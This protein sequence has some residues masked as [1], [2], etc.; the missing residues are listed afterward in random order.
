[1]PSGVIV[2]L[3]APG[4]FSKVNS[5]SLYLRHRTHIFLFIHLFFHDMNMLGNCDLDF[6][7]F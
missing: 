7:D 6:I 2:D 3:A 5:W 4:V 1:M